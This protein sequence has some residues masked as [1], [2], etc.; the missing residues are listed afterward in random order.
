MGKK[1]QKLVRHTAE[2]LTDAP[3]THIHTASIYTFQS[4]KPLVRTESLTGVNIP[5]VSLHDEDP[6]SARNQFQIYDPG[7]F[8]E[9]MPIPD[10][11]VETETSKRKGQPAITPLQHGCQNRWNGHY[12]ERISLKTLGLCIQLGH[13]M[14]DTCCNPQRAFNDDF[15]C[16]VYRTTL[17]L[18]RQRSLRTAT[19]PSYS[20]VHEWR[21]INYSNILPVVTAQM[22]WG[23]LSQ[24]SAQCSVL[25]VPNPEKIFPRI[26]KMPRLISEGRWLYALFVGI[27]TNFRLKRKFVSSDSIDPGIS[28]GW[29]YFVDERAYKGYLDDHKDRNQE[30]S[31]CA[32]HNAVNMADTKNARGLAATGVG[33]VDCARHNMKL[34]NAVGDLQK[35][36]KYINMDYLFFSAMSHNEVTVLNVSFY[37]DFSSKAI[38]FLVPK[39]H[40]PAHIEQCQIDFSFNL[41]RYVGRTD[42]E[43]PERGWANINPITSSTKE[44]GPGSRRDTL[45]DYFGDWN[46]KRCIW[47][48]RLLARKLVDAIEQKAKHQR[49]LIELE[50]C[51]KAQDISQ[52]RIE[53][54]AWEQDHSQT[55]PFQV[56]V[57]PETHAAVQLEL[58]RIE[59]AEL[60]S[61]TNISLHADVSPS[62]LISSGIDLEDQQRRLSLEIAALGVHATDHQLAKAQQHTNS[63]R[64][65]IE[66]WQDIQLL[67]MPF[68]SLLRGS[69]EPC[70]PASSTPVE[71]FQL[72]LPSAVANTRA[73]STISKADAKV[74]MAAE[75]YEVARAAL[76]NLARILNEDRTWMEVFKPLNRS[77]DLKALK[78]MWGKETEGTWHLSWIWKT[79]GVSENASVGLHDALHIEW[80]KARARAMRWEEEVD[81]L[82][83]E[84]QRVIAFLDWQGGWWQSQRERRDSES[85]D[86]TLREGLVA[87][88]ERQAS[89]RWQLS[90]HFQILWSP[91]TLPTPPAGTTT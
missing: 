39:F 69:E 7:D 50:S 23:Q 59:A 89:L 48:G 86:D 78:D 72:W 44:M 30:R 56:C 12:F 60:E 57:A 34:R 47:L 55:N 2:Q 8:L 15:P 88:A 20:V 73:R 65:K 3:P 28:K 91:P 68:V 25:H 84:Q 62:I 51:L 5:P 38:T 90:T 79:P 6:P 27:D 11:D 40:L 35:G 9:Y 87:Y 70:S 21:I 4:G 53:V 29:S 22:A 80:C 1:K 83:E 42:G 36:E 66:S 17:A 63:L 52:W 13:R 58:A 26:G 77:K 64:R 49:E 19:Q 76:A 24:D 46:W 54:E 74:N 10:D 37:L 85:L 41:S 71:A 14:D 31:T 45:D 82:K 81:L 61:G 33:T 18:I 16:A 67:Y 32:S 75:R 43:A